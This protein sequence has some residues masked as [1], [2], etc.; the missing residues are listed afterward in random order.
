M[1]RVPCADEE[2][3][4][5]EVTSLLS[6]RVYSVEAAI[7]MAESNTKKYTN[8]PK[9]QAWYKAIE[10]KHIGGATSVACPRQ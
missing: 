3:R 7:R 2:I 4:Q 5:A 10:Q 1:L 8:W 9:V 6:G